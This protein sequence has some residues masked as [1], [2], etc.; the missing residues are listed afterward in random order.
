MDPT[1]HPQSR[2]QSSSMQDAQEPQ[3]GRTGR[4]S[5][6][7][8]WSCVGCLY[9]CMVHGQLIGGGNG[10]VAGRKAQAIVTYIHM[11][12]C[13]VLWLIVVTIVCQKG[14]YES[15]LRNVDP[16]QSRF[17]INTTR[18]ELMCPDHLWTAQSCTIYA[19]LRKNP[20]TFSRNFICINNRAPKTLEL[21]GCCTLSRSDASSK[22]DKKHTCSHDAICHGCRADCPSSLP[23][24]I[25]SPYLLIAAWLTPVRLVSRIIYSQTHL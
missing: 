5:V 24:T 7:Q 3:L 8:Q 10:Y 20:F 22:S 12:V 4:G 17:F 13:A 14:D 9:A 1:H 25:R 23:V 19:K 18:H 2:L 15:M 16:F 11:G 6:S 21:R